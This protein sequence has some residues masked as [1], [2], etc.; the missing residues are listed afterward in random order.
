MVSVW[1]RVGKLAQTAR[2]TF[3]FPL[4]RAL[5]PVPAPVDKLELAMKVRPFISRD[6]PSILA[7]Q[8]GG[9]ISESWR[10][11]DYMRLAQ[12]G[13]LVLVAQLD[14]ESLSTVIGF[15]ALRRASDEAEIVALAVDARYRRL[16]A[17][18]AL[19]CKTC[20][21]TRSQ[22]IASVY[23]EVRASNTAARS[24]YSTAGFRLHYERKDYYDNPQEA[25]CVMTFN[26][27]FLD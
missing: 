16:G 20:E 26:A 8:A 18:R 23:L 19:V 6:M 15:L 12:S 2:N 10:E 7:L 17:G 1:F 27:R 24:L 5:L 11:A 25:A 22:A 4:S 3:R 21:W 9:G 14:E 13:G